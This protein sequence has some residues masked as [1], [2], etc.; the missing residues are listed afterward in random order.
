MACTL[1]WLPAAN[2]VLGAMRKLGWR[3]DG[4]SPPASQA[5]SAAAAIW[6]SPLKGPQQERSLP[7]LYN[8]QLLWQLLA[9]MCRQVDTVT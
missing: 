3:E 1:G 9:A 6:A 4:Y 8:M 5:P 2:D 7:Q